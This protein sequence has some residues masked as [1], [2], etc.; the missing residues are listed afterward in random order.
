[1]STLTCNRTADVAR[2][3]KSG[4]WSTELRSH[5]AQCATCR[6]MRLVVSALA[7]E[8]RR[9]TTGVADGG[10]VWWKAQLRGRHQATERATRPIAA[11]EIVT[12]VV[13]AAAGALALAR[14][15]PRLQVVASALSTEALS[16]PSGLGALLALGAGGVLVAL[17]LRL[18]SV[19]VRN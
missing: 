19:Y 15:W 3:A 5:A 2:A 11:V 4:T 16:T 10:L 17:L 8:R 13:G 7:R 12:I 9:P 6:D 1:M 14:V 18:M